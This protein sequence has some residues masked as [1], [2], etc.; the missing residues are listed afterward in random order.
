MTVISLSSNLSEKNEFLITWIT[1]TPSWF[2][3]SLF[4][5][6]LNRWINN[7][8]NFFRYRLSVVH[9][10][11]FARL[12]VNFYFFI[13]FFFFVTRF[14]F[15]C[16]QFTHFDDCWFGPMNLFADLLLYWTCGRVESNDDYWWSYFGDCPIDQ[17]TERL[18]DCRCWWVHFRWWLGIQTE[19]LTWTELI[20]Y[21]INWVKQ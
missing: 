8:I 18:I 12:F 19:G 2:T 9:V 11:L 4:T 21:W 7:S 20:R 10:L 6:F 15:T 14:V 17:P 3:N 13:L 16:I 1:A 5:H